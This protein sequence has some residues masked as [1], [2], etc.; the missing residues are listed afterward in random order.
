MVSGLHNEVSTFCRLPILSDDGKLHRIN[1][2]T[3]LNL[4]LWQDFQKNCLQTCLKN[5]VSFDQSQ[6]TSFSRVVYFIF[7][8]RC[9]DPNWP[10]V[11]L[12]SLIQ[13]LRTRSLKCSLL[14]NDKV[15]SL[16]YLPWLTSNR[17]IGHL[18]SD[19]F[20]NNKKTGY[21]LLPFYDDLFCFLLVV[22]FGSSV[23][24][25]RVYSFENWNSVT[26][27]FA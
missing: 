14:F 7:P 11:G 3:E 26:N 5:K 12:N 25:F 1:E 13:P 18:S 6:N 16:L 21:S 9:G 2:F 15:T 22:F 19:W 4:L 24:W 8:T 17:L 23:S 20:T 10:D 27:K